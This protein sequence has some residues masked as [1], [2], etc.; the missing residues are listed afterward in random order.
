MA[1]QAIPRSSS[2]PLAEQAWPFARLTEA[3]EVLARCS[4][5]HV[6]RTDL[7]P[8]PPGLE[9][10][11]ADAIGTWLAEVALHLGIEV[12]AVSAPY[13][14]LRTLARTAGPALVVIESGGTRRVLALLPGTNRRRVRVLTPDLRVDRV[15]VEDLQRALVASA[16]ARM[17][18]RLEQLLD[19]A[20]VPARARRR[21]RSSLL[22]EYLGATPVHGC[23]ILRP[24]PGA[25]FIHQLVQA[26]VLKFFTGLVGLQLFR[27]VVLVG[28]WALLGHGALEGRLDE[29]WLLAWALLL[30]TLVALGMAEVWFQG[31]AAIGGGAV[32]KGRLLRGALRLDRDEVRGEGSGQLLGRVHEAEALEMLAL[33]GGLLSVGAVFELIV[34]I[35]VLAMGAGGAV[36]AVA[37]LV[38]SLVVL[39]LCVRLVW[40]EWQWVS[41]R[42]SL[43]NGLVERMVGHRTRLAQEHPNHWHDGEDQELDD[44]QSRSCALDRFSI[45]LQVVAA[46]GWVLVGFALLV[47]AFVAGHATVAA[48]AV[49]VGG[50]LLAQQ[51]LGKV[52]SSVV[53]LGN[54]LI[55]WRQVRPLYRAAGFEPTPQKLESMS[56]SSPAPR[57]GE[58][59]L[60]ANSLVFGYP[61]R[62]RPVIDG[63]SLVL[64]QGDRV[65]LEGPSGGGKSTL[66]A[67]LA[68]MREPES[69]LL[70]LDGLDP[71]TL[72]TLGWTR[73]VATAPQF[74]ENHVFAETFAFNLLMGRGWP[75]SATD[76]SEAEQLCRELG[77]GDLLDRMPAGMLQVVGE[78]GWQLSH[79]ERSRLFLARAVLQNSR[80]VIL[81][82]SFAALDP[83]NLERAAR[84]VLERAPTVVVIA[85]P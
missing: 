31:R 15:R 67:L 4:R 11:S 72:G 79:G 36:H 16:E 75:A 77:L 33:S 13:G 44:Y 55:A 62:A 48:L 26:R 57:P 17:A 34:T 28:A 39:L 37:L 80:L 73:R 19:L 5:L 35:W 8:H 46:R 66:A 54:A 84:C 61:G 20:A 10:A 23:W 76:L 52:A 83:A 63:A 40:L 30:V 6:K 38:W 14:D 29:G 64:R 27:H 12:E 24:Q 42:L 21:V 82:E 71:P 50:I 9:Q 85:H 81:D 78:N 56:V 49:A 3:C 68:G 74:H 47:P 1:S 7:P 45:W 25:S 22:D 60:E 2:Q 51:S 59:L 70:L 18:D 53:T 65:L 69:G 43:T 32:L 58:V 41:S